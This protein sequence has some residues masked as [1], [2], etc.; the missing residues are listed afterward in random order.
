MGSVLVVVADIFAHES[1]QMPF[2]EHDHMVKQVS[3][4]TPNP[5]LCDSILPR[6]A[7]RGAN[8]FRPHAVVNFLDADGLPGERYAE[9]DFLV[10]QA[11]TSA[12]GDH[13]GAVVERVVRFRDASIRTRGSRVD[14]GRAFH[15]ESF[16]GSFVIEFLQEAAGAPGST[17]RPARGEPQAP[18]REITATDSFDRS[19]SRR[20][21]GGVAANATPF[22]YQATAMGL[23]WFRSRDS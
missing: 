21:A 18:C 7:K 17:T 19:D 12:A 11:K 2:I 15:G 13:D 22:P 20:L 23:Q 1:F 8:R 6:T 4:A 10:V 3:S 14:L 5:T 9:V 16:M